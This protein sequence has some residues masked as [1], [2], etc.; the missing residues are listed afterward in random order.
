MLGNVFMAEPPAHNNQPKNHPA[1]APGA[2][3]ADLTP[4]QEAKR[5]KFRRALRDVMREERPLSDTEM[6]DRFDDDGD[7]G[8]EMRRL[9]LGQ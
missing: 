9:L 2:D 7:L 3:D 4:E 6:A 8:T 1:R 5:R